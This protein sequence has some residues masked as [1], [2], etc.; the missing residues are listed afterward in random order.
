MTAKLVELRIGANVPRPFLAG[1]KGSNCRLHS[2][3]FLGS[4]GLAHETK[5]CE[6]FR[7]VEC[8]DHYLVCNSAAGVLLFADPTLGRRDLV[9]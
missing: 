3:L 5:L 1:R 9:T 2:S 6:L 7:G 4:R 8:D